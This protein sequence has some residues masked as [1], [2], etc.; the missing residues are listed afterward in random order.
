MRRDSQTSLLQNHD[1]ICA[2]WRES[3][4]KHTHN[5]RLQV[6]INGPGHV[7]PRAGF[8][9]ER[10]VRFVAIVYHV[11][12]ITDQVTIWMDS[13]LQTVKFPT[14]IAHLYASLTDVNRYAFPL[15]KKLK[16]HQGEKTKQIM[17]FITPMTNANPKRSVYYMWRFL[18]LNTVM[19]LLSS[20]ELTRL[21]STVLHS[22]F[23]ILQRP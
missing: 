21:N 13:V 14:C 19:N 9:E 12:L 20:F 15:E 18:D 6:H 16:N 2:T 22:K 4:Q 8:A 11:W 1:C 10:V 17:P 7:L 3:K 5:A 23:I